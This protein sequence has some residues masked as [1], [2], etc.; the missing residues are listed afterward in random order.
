MIEKTIIIGLIIVSIHVVTQPNHI[1]GR[2]FGRIGELLDRMHVGVLRRPLWECNIC[3]GGVW[4]LVLYPALFGFDW[5][6]IPVVAME[7]GLQTLISAILL[8]INEK[9]E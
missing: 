6:V 2:L 5:Y 3:M 4:T 1:F 7:I 9:N 8:Y